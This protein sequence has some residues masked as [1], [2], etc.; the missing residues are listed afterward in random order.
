MLEPIN[1]PSRSY[2]NEPVDLEY[3][4]DP[5][6]EQHNESLVPR[7]EDLTNM[8]HLMGQL[9]APFKQ[10]HPF[11]GTPV[12]LF[13]EKYRWGRWVPYSVITK[14]CMLELFRVVGKSHKPAREIRVC[15]AAMTEFA[16]VERENLAS[17]MNTK[18]CTKRIIVFSPTRMFNISHAEQPVLESFLHELMDMVS[19]NLGQEEFKKRVGIASRL[20]PL[21]EVQMQLELKRA[22]DLVDTLKQGGLM[23]QPGSA[24][25]QGFLQLESKKDPS[26]WKR[27]YFVLRKDFLTYSYTRKE[28]NTGSID[29]RD[30]RKGIIAL[31]FAN[32]KADVKILPNGEK[33]YCLILYTPFMN[34][35]MQ[36]KH[37]VALR[38]WLE[39]IDRQIR[40]GSSPYLPP[41]DSNPAPGGEVELRPLS[42]AVGPIPRYYKPRLE[43]QDTEGKRKVAKIEKAKTNIGRSSSNEI[44][45]LDKSVSRQHCRI[46]LEN[47]VCFI[48]DLGSEVGT[49]VNDRQVQKRALVPGDIVK[50]GAVSCLFQAQ[51]S[52]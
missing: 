44:R 26:G 43:Y 21:L 20:V 7:T 33:E 14:N 28:T 2:E 39:A 31:K 3:D 38:E 27:Q 25:K 11:T 41:R 36:A 29:P 52:P 45:V 42:Q 32:V 46:D 51:N 6:R 30:K 22:D 17:R 4:F 10:S 19:Q 48:V 18:L 49:I 47:N 35:R 8:W 16:T 15:F 40:P 12:T 9:R 1:E 34:Y 23:D 24:I 37:D 5:R 13:V 50:L